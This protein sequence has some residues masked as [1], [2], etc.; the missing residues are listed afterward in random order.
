MKIVQRNQRGGEV[1]KRHPVGHG[2]LIE[3]RPF[4]P[5]GGLPPLATTTATICSSTLVVAGGKTCFTDETKYMSI[6]GPGSTSGNS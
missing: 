3:R 5:P 2:K 4:A 6:V 1:F